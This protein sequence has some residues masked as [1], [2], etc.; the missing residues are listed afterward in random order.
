M[1]VN[2]L[3]GPDPAL[4]AL[5][6]KCVVCSRVKNTPFVTIDDCYY[7]YYYYYCYYYGPPFPWIKEGGPAE[8]Q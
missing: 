6:L 7:Y 3:A 2:G 1:W 8:Q 5:F 4:P